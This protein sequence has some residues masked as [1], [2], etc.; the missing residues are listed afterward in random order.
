[1]PNFESFVARH[2][3]CSAQ[4]IIENLERHE[5]I[6]AASGVI[7]RSPLERAD[8]KSFRGRTESGGSMSMAK[9]PKAADKN[10][11]ARLRAYYGVHPWRCTHHGDRSEVFAYA[12][13]SGTWELVLEVR[14]SSGATAEEL[15]IYI[16]NLVNDRR[17]DQPALEQAFAALDGVLQD[18]LTF[19]TEQEADHAV[20]RLKKLGFESSRSQ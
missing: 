2:S 5:G 17:E 9:K 1:M 18:G 7:A 8:A 13:A 11:K 6:S 14:S 12:E 19:T 15:A 3:E 16:V 20:E 4:A 10:K